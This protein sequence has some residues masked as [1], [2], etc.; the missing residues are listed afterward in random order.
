M[1]KIISCTV[2]RRA[3]LLL[4]VL[5]VFIFASG[6]SPSSKPA[7]DTERRI[8]RVVNGLLPEAA[9]RN[10][11]GPKATL[12]NRM[13][14]YH[15]PGVSIAVIHN[16]RIEWARGFGVREQGTSDPV[17]E[18][19]VFQAG[20]ISKPIF[21][22]AVM[23]LVQEG[24]LDLDE[25]VNRYLK[26]WKVPPNGSWQPR[27]TL[28]QLLSHS[29]GLTVHG[30]PGYRRREKLPSVLD[31]LNGEPP[32]NTARIEVNILPGVQF[33]YSGGGTTV[34]Q[35]LVVD[36]LSQP[37]PQIMRTL[38]LG[39]L[40]ME[41]STYEQPLPEGWAGWAATAHP[42]KGKPLEGKW[43]VYPEMA[44]AGLWTTPSDLARAGIELQL[45]L[46]GEG[47][48]FLATDR[49]TQMLTAGVDETIGLGFF[50]SG[51]DKAVR[52]GHGG[53]DEGFVAEMTMYK[54]LGMGSVIMINSNEGARIIREIERAIAKEYEW[55]GYFP[56][57]KL[58]SKLA[59]DLLGAY[60]GEYVG[61]AGFQCTLTQQ[62][63]TLYLKAA[64]QAPI[65]LHPESH[66]KF[67]AT[68][69]NAEV[70]FN[71]SENGEVKSLTLQQAGKQITAER[72]R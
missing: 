58:A 23:R 33:R 46:K 43:H 19:T 21:A 55:P 63:G 66:A 25:D 30:F 18:T 24:K 31:I 70:T 20:S 51:K 71:K 29:A 27:I 41:R 56:E 14:Y 1:N 9:F 49:V 60:V 35:Q 53:W 10:R 68:I 64:D 12:K 42:S 2:C 22:L 3:R 37:F 45:A 7:N 40:D 34:A 59:S 15:T 52:F 48:R 32:S 69:L 11:Y 57:E 47:K 5:V 36:L 28:R 39:P 65:E 67:F 50:L 38:V 61:K 62:N 44:A 26:S 54:D 16:Y 8:E 72:K 4:P 13:A 6:V 17:T